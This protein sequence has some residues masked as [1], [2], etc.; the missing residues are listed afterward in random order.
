MGPSKEKLAALETRMQTLGILP[1]DIE[2]KFIKSS[3]RGGQ[4]VNKTSSAV[5]L[6]HV[7][8]SITVKCGAE[9]SQTL[10]R[11]L[12][13]RRLVEKVAEVQAGGTPGNPENLKSIRKQK[14]KRRKR[15]RD[16]HQ[17][18]ALPLPKNAQ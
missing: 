9:R 2:E 4:K 17:A 10:N 15:S 7:P 16:K 6:R 8:T 3:G 1:G 11:F 12:A 18:G 13:L 5:F 14:Q